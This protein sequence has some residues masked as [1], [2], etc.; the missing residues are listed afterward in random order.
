M[1]TYYH[2]GYPGLVPG[3]TIQPA[4]PHVEDGCPICVA[5][6][7][8]RRYTVGEY[9]RWL[10]S[11]PNRQAALMV[12]KYLEGAD[13][14]EPVDPPSKPNRVYITSHEGY[15]RWYAAR[16]RGDLYE[17]VP[18]SKIEESDEDQFSSW[19]CA[20][21]TV[22]RVVER[23]VRLDRRDRRALMREW[24]KRDRRAAERKLA[25]RRAPR[26]IYA[27]GDIHG[28]VDALIALL[29]A[30][31]A[32]GCDTTQDRLVFLGDYIDRGPDS[33]AVLAVVAAMVEEGYAIA[34][35]GNHEQMMVDAY[36]AGE[37]SWEYDS[38][39]YQGGKETA[40]SFS[41][42]TERVPAD[43]V[44]WVASLP[45]TVT[46]GRYDFVHAGFLSQPNHRVTTP[47][48]D[49]LW[50]REPFLESDFDFGNVVV[51]GHTSVD[52]PVVRPNRIGIDTVL[53][54]GYPTAVCLE[55]GQEPRFITWT[56]NAEVLS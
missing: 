53:R 9:R 14:R 10:M 29:G 54:T 49:M 21:A 47:D 25:M 5:R 43:I 7:E 42:T 41:R 2:G 33:A 26:R 37:G 16:S 40:R 11:Q 34:L 46:I 4:P 32:D 19:T 13:D 36:A 23:H 39:W 30:I 56:S 6:A 50:I 17:V 38:W 8:G 35:R 51:H 12:L 18:D 44:K 1:T 52:A 27:I 15:A 24:E 22:K 45:L 31:N 3:D 28:Y 55:E 20:T 48:H